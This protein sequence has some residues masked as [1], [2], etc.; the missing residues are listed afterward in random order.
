[1]IPVCMT[2]TFIQGH[3]ITGKLVLVHLLLYSCRKQ[4]MFMMV[5]FVMEMT[6]KRSYKYSEYG[7]LS[8][9]VFV[10]LVQV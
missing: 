5:D 7:C 9:F 2:L 4:D 6:V 1:M 3:R 10:F 8:F